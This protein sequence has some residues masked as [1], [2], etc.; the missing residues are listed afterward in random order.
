M[1]PNALSF[2]AREVAG[3]SDAEETWLDSVH[4]LEGW[5][6]TAGL[7]AATRDILLP[8]A[9]WRTREENLRRHAEHRGC[10][11]FVTGRIC[12]RDIAS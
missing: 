7:S 1:L 2:A 10:R 11:R 4:I 9:R 3:A 6:T 8:E 12:T 5:Q